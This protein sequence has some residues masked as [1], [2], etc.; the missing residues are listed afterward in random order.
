M[1]KLVN[2]LILGLLMLLAQ[3]SVQA[4]SGSIS[5]TVVDQNGA[6]IPGASVTVKGTAGQEYTV[7]TSGN[8]TYTIPVVQNGVYSVTVTS[9]NFKTSITQNVKVDVGTPATVDVSLEAG[10]IEETVLVVSG[11]EVLQTQTATV[12]TTI[13][14]RQILETPIQSRDALDLVTTLPGTNTVG[15]VRTSSVNGLPKGAI[16]ITIDGVDVQDN[17]L[18]SSDGFFTYVRP[19]IDAID[20]VTVS[21]AVPGSESAGDGAVRVQFATRRGTNSYSGGLYWQHRDE[22]LNA[23]NFLNN[24]QNIPRQKI[25]LN[26]FGGRVGGPIPFFNFGDD[27]PWWHSGKDRSFFFVNYEEYRIPEASPTRTKNLLNTAAQGGSFRYSPTSGAIQTFNVYTIAGLAGLP[28]TP[29]PTV[30]GI[31]SNIRAATAGTGSFLVPPS[32]NTDQFSFTNSGMQKRR[33]LATRFDINIGKNHSFEN[34]NN[35]QP[36]RST[37]DFLNALDSAFPGFDNAGAQ[38]SNRWSNSAALR[39]SFGQNIV[40]EARY[41]QLWG[42]S[43]FTLVGGADYFDTAAG[44]YALGITGPGISTYIARNAETRRTSPMKDLTDTLTWIKGSHTFSFGGQYKIIKTKTNDLNQIA[45]TVNF[46]VIAQDTALLA[47]NAF[48]VNNPLFLALPAADRPNATQ[49]TAMATLYATL[50]G[51][52]SSYAQTAYLGADGVYQPSG[53][54]AREVQQNTYGLFFQDTWRMRQNLTLTYGVRWQPQ[55]RIRFNT[56]NFSRLSNFDML[57]DVSGVNNFFTPGT[58]TGVTPTVVGTVKGERA[59]PTDWNNWAP[60]IGIVWSPEFSKGMFHTLFGDS[61]RSVIR[62]GF[63][64]AFIRE[65]TLLG[66]NSLGVNP[67][68]S[69]SVGRSIAAGNFTAGTL[70]RTPGNPNITPAAF[71]PTPV[72]PRTLTVVDAAVAWSP[73]IKSGYVDSWT[74]GYQRE[75]DRNT[76]VEFRYVANRGKGMES[77]YSLNETNAI[78]NGFAADFY[79]AQANLAANNAAGGTRAGSFGYF[80][81]GTG[82]VPLPI[83]HSYIFGAGNDPNNAAQYSTPGTTGT[84]V[85]YKNA[86]FAGTLSPFNAN[87]VGLAGAMENNFRNRGLAAGRPSNFFNNCPTTLGFCFIID[88]SEYSEY[89]AGVVELRRRLSNGLRI[90]ASYVYAK[91]FTNAFAGGTSFGGIGVA[92]QNNNSSVTLRNR[93]LDRSEAQVDLRHAFKFDATYDL[94][95]GKGRTYFGNSNWATNALLGG[96]SIAPVLRWQ[97]GSPFLLENVQLVGMT[98][99]ELQKAIGVYKNSNIQLAGQADQQQVTWLPTDIIVNTIR[100]FNTQPNFGAP[101]ATGYST[102]GVPT[103]RYIAPSGFGNCA[104]TFA[105]NCGFRKLVLYGPSFFKLDAALIKKIQFDEKR[106]IELRATFFDVL[107]KT[108][109]RVGGWTANVFALTNFG[110]TQFGQLLAGT[111]YQ[112][113]FGSNDPGGRVIDLSFRF[114][115]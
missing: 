21:T 30:A 25:R 105:G 92:D 68:G 57:Y 12:G 28:N 101:G 40:N 102:L 41:S 100:A 94:P 15:T 93:D 54:L 95:F 66:P 96:W 16:S 5:G 67:G 11:G 32:L 33:F 82:T 59:G 36:F 50:T 8:G 62:A 1:K 103:G 49:V 2:G 37:Q 71:V 78:E 110:S 48:S 97:S 70:F 73:D 46:G 6:V 64:R 23:N 52:V 75:I 89:D 4:Q 26:Q 18:R 84:D 111:S 60:S 9:P 61:G 85:L 39:S 24:K 22:S 90:Q 29:D 3:L 107:N 106:N 114:N 115:F 45:P 77:L 35:Y 34:V 10:K 65:G 69:F 87:I 81:V 63:S 27:G 7:T 56:Q 88:N 83:I 51:R 17:F 104:T 58:M 91:A 44:R 53:P 72:Y 109:W 108:N 74:V 42:N 99:K 47:P 79:R 31:L 20:E 98:K 19:R 76:V 86:G 113:P 14:G 13:T 80:G 38:N 55:E 112:D 43:D